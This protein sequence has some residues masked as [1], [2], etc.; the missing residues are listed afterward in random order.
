MAH[1]TCACLKLLPLAAASRTF[2][3]EFIKGWAAS[4]VLHGNQWS[5]L[6]LSVLD[7]ETGQLLEYRALRRHPRLDPDWNTSY[8]NELGR[9]FQGIGVD[10]SDPSKQ[11]IEGTNTFHPI[12]YENMPLDQRKEIAFSKVVFTFCP[13]KSDPN[14][15]RITIAGQNI[16]YPGDVGTKTASLGLVKLLL[17]RVLLRKGANL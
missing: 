1:R 17:N 6:A 13:D 15:T 14:Q 16:K 2:P 3:S 7:P 5:P 12:R 8:S 11:R 10:P 4:E 9:L